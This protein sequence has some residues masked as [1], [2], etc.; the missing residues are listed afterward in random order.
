MVY[1]YVLL[2]E[3]NKY[4]VGKTNNCNL[5][6]DQHDKGK[7][8][9]WTSL[10][11][12]IKMHI[13]YF[14]CDDFDEDKYTIKYMA[15]F[16]IDNVRGG[17]FCQLDLTKYRDVIEKMILGASNRCYNCGSTQHFLTKCN[18]LVVQ[19]DVQPVVQ[20]VVQSDV[21]PDVRSDVRSDVQP[22]EVNWIPL[23][24][25][26]QVDMVIYFNI[27]GYKTEVLLSTIKKFGEKSYLY[28]LAA[29]EIESIRDRED[30]IFID[31][32]YKLFESI[33]NCLRYDKIMQIPR[34]DILYYVGITK[35]EFNY[36]T[37]EQLV[38]YHPLVLLIFSE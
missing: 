29:K 20:P 38:N 23:K 11:K 32:D 21:Q 17:S 28:R 33:I 9:V 24:I 34:E 27:G 36:L 1:I 5:R 31:R 10:Y 25:V 19:S 6:L 2:L 30:R 35:E 8:S 22:I 26:K 15:E 7:G 16:G 12:P 3:S 37:P 13:I 18:Q 14:N 4:Y